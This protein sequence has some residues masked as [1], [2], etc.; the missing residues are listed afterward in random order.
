MHRLVCLQCHDDGGVVG[1]ADQEVADR[2]RGEPQTVDC[3]VQWSGRL[4]H[5]QPTGAPTSTKHTTPTFT[6]T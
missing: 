5:H 3:G 4:V 2:V 1:V 6:N